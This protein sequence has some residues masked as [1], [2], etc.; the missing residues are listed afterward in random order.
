[1]PCSLVYRTQN[2]LNRLQRVQKRSSVQDSQ[3][4]LPSFQV[5]RSFIITPILDSPHWLPMA[6]RIRDKIASFSYSSLSDWFWSWISVQVQ[7]CL[8]PQRPYGQLGTGSPGRL[9]RLSQNSWAL[10]RMIF[11]RSCRFIHHRAVTVTTPVRPLSDNTVF[12]EY[13]ASKQKALASQR[14][15]SSTGRVMWNSFPPDVWALW[16]TS[17]RRRHWLG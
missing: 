5:R 9:P 13:P 14:P 8:R 17:W 16:T 1:M 3:S 11:P 2:L 10:K 7:C 15:F 12:F 4:K 6:A